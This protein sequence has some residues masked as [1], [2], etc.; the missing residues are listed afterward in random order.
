M[1]ITN[2]EIKIELAAQKTTELQTLTTSPTLATFNQ[3]IIE[4]EKLSTN[5]EPKNN[6]FLVVIPT[7]I[8]ISSIFSVLGIYL[9]I[10]KTRKIE[11]EHEM[12]EI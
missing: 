5:V 7:A 11:A 1:S 9:F 12:D 4:E 10:K 8:V 2:Q 3:E 6:V